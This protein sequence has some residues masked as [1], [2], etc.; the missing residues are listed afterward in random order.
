MKITLPTGDYRLWV[1]HHNYQATHDGEDGAVCSHFAHAHKCA[2]P[3]A[4]T[5]A[6]LIPIVSGVEMVERKTRGEA[7][8][9]PGDQFKRRTGVQLAVARA[10]A[11]LPKSDRALIWDRVWNR[12]PKGFQNEF[13]N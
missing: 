11:H 6:E 13:G 1:R 2:F 10:I 12:K 8:C 5:V 9:F 7:G 4:V 3:N